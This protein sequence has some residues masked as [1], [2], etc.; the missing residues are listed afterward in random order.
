MPE[1]VGVVRAVKGVVVV[2]GLAEEVDAVE[3]YWRRRGRG[4]RKGLVS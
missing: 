3:L 1:G 2:E 4:R